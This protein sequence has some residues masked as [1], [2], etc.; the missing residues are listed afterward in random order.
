MMISISLWPH[1]V[2][3]NKCSMGLERIVRQFLILALVH[4]MFVKPLSANVIFP[5]PLSQFDA[6]QY[7]QVFDLQ[8]QGNMKQATREMARLESPL[9]KVI[10]CLTLLLAWQ[11][12]M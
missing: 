3:L 10:F 7:I 8:Q 6:A 4:I 1:A 9:L 11:Q 2:D 12:T 5:T